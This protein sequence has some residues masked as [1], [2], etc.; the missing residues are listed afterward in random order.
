LLAAIR[1]QRDLLDP[2][3]FHSDWSHPV[4]DFGPGR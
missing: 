4:E 2:D 1:L 3:T